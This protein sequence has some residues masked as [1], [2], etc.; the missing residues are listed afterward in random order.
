MLTALDEG[1]CRPVS[2]YILNVVA[3]SHFC[4]K[5]A[6]HAVALLG[7]AGAGR[8]VLAVGASAATDGG[9]VRAD[10]GRIKD[11]LQL[12]PAGRAPTL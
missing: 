3:L 12:P 11:A 4:G 6:M 10:A 8:G 5:P 7:W 9:L 2:R 1:Q